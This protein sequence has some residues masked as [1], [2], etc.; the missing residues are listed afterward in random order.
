V[1]IPKDDEYH[2]PNDE[3]NPGSE[4]S[5][6][7]IDAAF[8]IFYSNKKLYAGLSVTHLL[9]PQLEL[10]ENY[11]LEIPRTYY[12]TAGYNIQL[13][14]PL[15]ELQPS[16][17]I[18]TMELS[19]FFIENDTL[20]PVTKANTLKGMLTQTQVDVS[21]RMMYKKTFWGG[22]AWRKQ[23]A[24]S[25]LLGGKFKVIEVGYSFDYP[26]SEFR[27]DSWGSHELF[28]KYT[29]DMGKKKPVRNKHKSVRIL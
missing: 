1:E 11:V 28:L 5:G 8:G 3:A 12:F 13:N 26:I 15:L 22:I 25:I 9:S 7:S 10:D 21:L 23:D 20:V 2:D 16:V 27:K 14:N 29:V 4:V 18:K 6:T 19:S 17:L 24:V